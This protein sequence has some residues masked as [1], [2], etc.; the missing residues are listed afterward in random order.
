LFQWLDGHGDTYLT[1]YRNWTIPG[2]GAP[3]NLIAPF[4]D[5]LYETNNGGHVFKRYDA[6]NHRLIVEWS[7]MQ[8]AAGGPLDTFE[9]ILYDPAYYPTSSGDGIIVFQYRDIANVDGGENYATVGIQNATQTDGVLYTFANVYS[10]GAAPLAAGRAIRFMPIA[11]DITSVPNA[12]ARGPAPGLEGNHPNPF[13]GGT[14][15]S[16][17]LADA[18]PARLM[19][20]DTSGRTVRSLFNGPLSS[21]RHEIRWDGKDDRGRAVSSGVYFYRMEAGDRS[22]MRRMIKLD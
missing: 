21:G 22:L 7:H 16:L 9:A 12:E 19:I 1:D 6:L 3:Q 5:D 8:N 13:F 14:V 4:W 20:Y 11:V 2:A 15:I 10:A 18:G 17:A